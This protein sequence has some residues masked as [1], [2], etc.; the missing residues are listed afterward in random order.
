MAP[1][2]TGAPPS[3]VHSP[4]LAANGA[5]TGVFVHAGDVAVGDA[6]VVYYPG[7]NQKHMIIL[8]PGNPGILGFYGPFLDSLHNELGGQVSIL[9][10]AHLGHTPDG[11]RTESFS[12]LAQVDALIHVIDACKSEGYE[13]I[14]IIG[15]SVGTWIMVQALKARLS[16]IDH[17]FLLFPT[18]TRIVN[19]PNGDHLSWAFRPPMP[20]VISMLSYILRVLPLFVL[21]LLFRSWPREQVLVLRSMLH[22]PS[23]IY[24]CLSMGHEEMLTIRE[25][26]DDADFL[27]QNTKKI[28]A[29]FA[30]KD[31]W[32]GENRATVI[33]TLGESRRVEICQ[34][35]MPHAFCLNH[36]EP[37]AARCALWYME[38]E[39]GN[40]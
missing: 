10:H 34:L 40:L 27:R 32:V 33:E 30:A 37:M 2:R 36:G 8:V 14:T 7:T 17:M 25:L 1:T 16:S 31:D 12:L 39:G 9:A 26:G 38:C 3:F 23:T 4:A 21:A 13:R 35:K 28:W 29:Y 11:P 15:H 19:T 24:H 18:I 22:S 5:Y 20:R 6:A